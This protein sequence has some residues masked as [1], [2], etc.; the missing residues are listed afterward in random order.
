M[1]IFNNDDLNVH[2]Y[3]CHKDSSTYI[4]PPILSRIFLK[5]PRIFVE[6]LPNL[7]KPAHHKLHRNDRKQ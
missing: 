2:G 1:K 7:L 4:I 3:K 6:P 5:V